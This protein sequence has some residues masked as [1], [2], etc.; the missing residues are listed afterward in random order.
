[1]EII[2]FWI[3][4]KSSLSDE[5]VSSLLS[6]AAAAT[7]IA[8][9]DLVSE[10]KDEQFVYMDSR[11]RWHI[12]ALYSSTTM[13]AGESSSYR[14]EHGFRSSCLE[15]EA[16]DG[17]MRQSTFAFCERERAKVNV[18]FV[19]QSAAINVADTN[20]N[21]EEKRRVAG[22]ERRARERLITLWF[23]KNSECCV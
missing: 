16:N 18:G 11:T 8:C 12:L 15:I 3:L 6:T 5:S 7:A 21:R 9:D 22:D 1:M 23:S 10:T 4:L 2:E 17:E 14:F 13:T 19:M 20:K